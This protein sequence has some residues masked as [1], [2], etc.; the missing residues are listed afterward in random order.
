[1]A[2]QLVNPLNASIGQHRD[3]IFFNERKGIA[4]KANWHSESLTAPLL[5]SFDQAM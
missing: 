3:E 4:L 1:M 2:W 5:V